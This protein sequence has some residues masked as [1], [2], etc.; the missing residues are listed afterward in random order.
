MRRLLAFLFVAVALAAPPRPAESRLRV[1]FWVTPQEDEEPA[2]PTKADFEGDAGRRRRPDYRNARAGR[3]PHAADCDGPGWGHGVWWMKPSGRLSSR[4]SGCPANSS[5]GL[6]RAQDGLRV[7][8]DPTADHEPVVTGAIESLPVSGRA[9]LLDTVESVA[10]LGDSILSRAAVRLAVLFVTD[11]D[12]S[13]YRDDLTNPVINR[14]DMRDMSRR[15]P[16]CS[17]AGE[18][19]Q[20]RS[21]TGYPP[22][23]RFYPPLEVPERGLERGVPD[24]SD[25]GLAEASGGASFFCRSQREIPDAVQ[26]ALRTIASHYSVELLLPERTPS[27][28]AVSLESPGQSLNFRS[29]FRK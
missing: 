16:G 19:I 11:S 13:N 9:A 24:R 1:P 5:V 2:A 7:V 23:A 15:F 25:A 20:G 12:V 26:R 8:V 21:C 14:S 4:S 3:R 17:G 10:E 18:D 27:S 28:F 29:R 22:D 6:L